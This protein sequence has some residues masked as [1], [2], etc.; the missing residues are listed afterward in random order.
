MTRA[1]ASHPEAAA[2]VNHRRGGGERPWSRSPE[3][4]FTGP[5]VG[6]DSISTLYI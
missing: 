1:A 5:D 3:W 4:C 6:V 2:T